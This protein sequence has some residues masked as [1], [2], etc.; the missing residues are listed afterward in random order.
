MDRDTGARRD[1]HAS[2]GASTWLRM[3]WGAVLLARPGQVLAAMGGHPATP[4]GRRLLRV[5]AARQLLQA[6]VSVFRP[7]PTVLGLGAAVDGLHAATCFGFAVL[8]RTWR[9]AA[10][11]DGCVAAAVG[12]ATGASAVRRTR[13]R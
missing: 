8:D 11:V 13:R 2:P 6:T 3:L 5:L 12:I 4:A 9:R 1:G 10:A 7:T